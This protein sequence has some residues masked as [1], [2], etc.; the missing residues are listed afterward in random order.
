MF[1]VGEESISRN[2]IELHWS[3]SQREWWQASLVIISVQVEVQRMMRLRNSEVN[4]NRSHW[5]PC[6]SV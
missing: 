1:G 6:W 3:S 5:I 2:H 4:E